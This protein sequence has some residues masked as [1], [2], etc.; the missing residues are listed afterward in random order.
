[1]E[2]QDYINMGGEEPEFIVGT[3]ELEDLPAN[4]Y[5]IIQHKSITD[6]RKGTSDVNV[7]QLKKFNGVDL[8]ENKVPYIVKGTFR[9]QTEKVFWTK[10]NMPVGETC[11]AYCL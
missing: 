6:L 2:I 9:S 1:M 8:S 10:I 3:G 11:W 5:M 7:V 4:C